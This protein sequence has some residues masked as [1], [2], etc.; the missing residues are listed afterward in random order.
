MD[1]ASTRSGNNL[2]LIFYQISNYYCLRNRNEYACIDIH[3]PLY[4]QRNVI[5]KTTLFEKR[6]AVEFF[7]SATNFV[8]LPF[9]QIHFG[10]HFCGVYFTNCK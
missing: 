6:Y 1:L 9:L 2:L 3:I 7:S 10:H 5:T 8:E 4:H